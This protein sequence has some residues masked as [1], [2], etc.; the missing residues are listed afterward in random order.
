MSSQPVRKTSMAPSPSVTQMCSITCSI[1]SRSSLS[2]PSAQACS[3][4]WVRAL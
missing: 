4:S 3:D 2:D 1:R